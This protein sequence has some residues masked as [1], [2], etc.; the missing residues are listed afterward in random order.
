MVT[1]L[2]ALGVAVAAVIFFLLTARASVRAEPIYAWQTRPAAA[3]G[4]S[5]TFRRF[6][7]WLLGQSK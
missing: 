6:V 7:R 4:L 2:I 3:E 5:A 1:P